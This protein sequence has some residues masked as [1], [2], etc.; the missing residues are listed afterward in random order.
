MMAAATGGCLL[1][2]GFDGCHG[3]GITALIVDTDESG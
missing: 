2:P 1:K 3:A